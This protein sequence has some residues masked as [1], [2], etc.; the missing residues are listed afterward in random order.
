MLIAVISNYSLD[1][2]IMLM[3]LTYVNMAGNR[4]TT[5]MFTPQNRAKWT[6]V[7]IQEFLALSEGEGDLDGSDDSVLM[8]H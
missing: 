1:L 4:K 8:N 3:K 6:N 2:V 5:K 7:E